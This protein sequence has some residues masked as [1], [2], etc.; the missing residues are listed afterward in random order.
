M[1]S[2]RV[3][4][5]AAQRGHVDGLADQQPHQRDPLLGHHPHAHPGGESDEQVP[6]LG[7]GRDVFHPRGRDQR[8]QLVDEHLA[9]QLLLAGEVGVEGLLADAGGL[10]GVARGSA[11]ESGAPTPPITS[12]CRIRTECSTSSIVQFTVCGMS[13]QVESR[14]NSAKELISDQDSAKN[15]NSRI[16]PQSPIQLLSSSS[17]ASH[18]KNAM[19]T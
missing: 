1:A 13:C 3:V 6:Q 4:G 18:A 2:R 12:G 17:R 11:A 8:L 7:Q 14:Q 19:N 10:P 5:Q 9:Q 16:E 15:G